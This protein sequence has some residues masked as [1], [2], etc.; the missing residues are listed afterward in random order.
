[1]L[2]KIKELISNF[3]SNTELRAELEQKEE[4]CENLK[5]QLKDYDISLLCSKR[6]TARGVEL[7]N[8]SLKARAKLN[9]AEQ[10]QVKEQE[11]SKLKEDKYA[12]I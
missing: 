2:N 6:M 10:L 7:H 9:I 1:M 5:N 3:K 8:L 12:L 11:C 4:E